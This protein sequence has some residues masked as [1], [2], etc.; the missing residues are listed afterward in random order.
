MPS[1]VTPHHSLASQTTDARIFSPERG[2]TRRRA[3]PTL[4]TVAERKQRQSQP[5]RLTH[6]VQ[7]ARRAGRGVAGRGPHRLGRRRRGAR[8]KRWRQSPRATGGAAGGGGGVGGR[9]GEADTDLVP[10]VQVPQGG[11]RGEG[12]RDDGGEEA[13]ARAHSARERRGPKGQKI[14]GQ[15]VDSR[16]RSRRDRAPR[17][18][19]VARGRARARER[20][21]HRRRLQVL[22]Q[23]RRGEGHPAQGSRI[24]RREANPKNAGSNRR[25]GGDA[26]E[27]PARRRRSRAVPPRDRR[28]T[29][30]ARGR[31]RGGVAHADVIA[32]ARRRCRRRPSGSRGRRRR[33]RDTR[34]RRGSDV[35][36]RGTRPESSTPLP[37]GRAP[38]SPTIR[39]RRS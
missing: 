2:Q 28:R 5:Q 22:R 10:R 1:S 12:A 16:R 17:A 3:D 35:P 30:G 15:T 11:V 32:H 14:H 4:P 13:D 26:G 34:R 8:T 38:A 24:H 19:R 37:R 21:A 36:R 23:G 39:S 33:W 27:R 9:R 20:L 7:G 6:R 31:G 25:A 18:P 29:S